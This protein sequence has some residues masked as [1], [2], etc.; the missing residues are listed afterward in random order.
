MDL[1]VRRYMTTSPTTVS[2]ETTVVE[3]HRIMRRECIRHLPVVDGLHH[4]VGLVSLRDLDFAETFRPFDGDVV[5]VGDAMFA[6]ELYTV[7]PG[8]DML[9]VARHLLDTKFGCAVVMEAGRV[10]GMFT[11]IDALRAL[12]DTVAATRRLGPV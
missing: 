11:V 4:L 9:E 12:I 1:H 3:A 7:E 10:V 2:P 6:K 8:T 5:R